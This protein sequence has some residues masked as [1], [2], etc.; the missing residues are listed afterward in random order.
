MRIKVAVAFV[1]AILAMAWAAAEPEVSALQSASASSQE[2]L[3]LDSDVAYEI[4]DMFDTSLVEV[5][6]LFQIPTKSD[7]ICPL[8]S[9]P[10]GATPCRPWS[11]LHVAY[12]PTLPTFSPQFRPC[13]ID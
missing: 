11:P 13:F 3:A 7:P 8:K 6:S 4:N 10:V 5:R 12:L 9:V 2:V 1:M